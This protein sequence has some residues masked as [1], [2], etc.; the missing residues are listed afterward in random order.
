MNSYH[1][2]LHIST[3]NSKIEL[4]CC[5]IDALLL[6]SDLMHYHWKITSGHSKWNGQ[7]IKKP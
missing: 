6:S 5:N 2:P 1:T 4:T 7:E 3:N